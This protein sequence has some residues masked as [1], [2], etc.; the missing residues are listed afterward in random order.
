MVFPNVHCRFLSLRLFYTL[1]QKLKNKFTD[2]MNTSERTTF[3][4]HWNYND[5]EATEKKFRELIPEMT[6]SGNKSHCLQL[7]TQIARTLG[8]QRKFDEAH[9]MLDEVEP[10]LSNE[11]PRARVRYHLERG[12]VF[13]SSGRPDE[14]RDQFLK[15]F[16]L[17]KISGEDDLAVDAAHMMGIVEKGEASVDWNVKAMK[18]AEGS[19]DEQAN[20]WLGSLYNNLGWTYFDMKNYDKALELFCKDIDWFESK[21]RVTQANIARWSAAKTKRMQGKV[22]EAL[23]MQLD[24]KE[25]IERTK[26]EDGYVYEE[27]AECYLIKRNDEEAKKYAGIAYDILSGD[28][29]LQANEQA[30]LERLKELGGKK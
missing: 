2:R 29:W 4:S 1:K 18:L 25:V 22:D 17:A 12:R 7:L 13:N 16:E 11:Y 14:A 28:I 20:N 6:A 30:R 23:S 21:G 9:E 19:S 24:L 8:L 5:P 10:Q 15:A 3:D 27:L 26:D